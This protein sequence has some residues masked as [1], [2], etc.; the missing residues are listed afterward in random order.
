MPLIY[1]H[2][3][4][5]SAWNSRN[6]NS[7]N[8]FNMLLKSRRKTRTN[9]ASVGSVFSDTRKVKVLSLPETIKEKSTF[10]AKVL[11]RELVLLS[12]SD[13]GPS[14]ETSI[15]P[16]SFQ[17]VREPLPFAYHRRKTQR[18]FTTLPTVNV[19]SFRVQTQRS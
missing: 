13:E 1:S 11:S 16:L 7:V 19:S 10:R 15:F 14:L 8:E 4:N 2:L 9:V 6:K 18:A 17:V 3:Q 12:T 5:I